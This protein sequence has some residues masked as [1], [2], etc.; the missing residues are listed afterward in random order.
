LGGYLRKID[1]GGQK[2]DQK[3][4]FYCPKV[5]KSVKN[6]SFFVT[7]WGRLDGDWR[8]GKNVKNGSFLDFL[9]GVVKVVSG[10]SNLLV[11]SAFCNDFMIG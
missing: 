11:F 10:R 5:G 7:F 6:G 8:I 4:P 9:A 3:R 2:S 1:G